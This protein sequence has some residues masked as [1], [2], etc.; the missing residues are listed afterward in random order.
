[1]NV[2]EDAIGKKGTLVGDGEDEVEWRERGEERDGRDAISGADMRINRV[3]SARTRR[4]AGRAKG[5]EGQIVTW[6]GGGRGGQG[7]LAGFQGLKK[8]PLKGSAEGEN[9]RERG[10][11]LRE[12]IERSAGIAREVVLLSLV[13]LAFAS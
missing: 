2:N 4:S 5:A 8:K 3:K 6:K 10:R 7:G 12:T 11:T 9:G 13:A 1:M